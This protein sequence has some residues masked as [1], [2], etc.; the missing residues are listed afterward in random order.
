M[1]TKLRL[2][3]PQI[4]SIKIPERDLNV[5]KTIKYLMEGVNEKH[6]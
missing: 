3:H 1:N 6:K 2:V 4:I 5:Q